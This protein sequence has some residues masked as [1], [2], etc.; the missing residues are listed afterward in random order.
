MYLLNQ[1]SRSNLSVKLRERDKVFNYIVA[2]AIEGSFSCHRDL[3]QRKNLQCLIL[4][5]NEQL[6]VLYKVSSLL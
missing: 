1:S 3:C 4:K 5:M 2:G 6:E